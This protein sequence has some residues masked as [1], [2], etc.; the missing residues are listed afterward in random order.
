MRAVSET[1]YELRPARGAFTLVELLVVIGIIALLIAIL[2]PALSRARAA[3]NEV[4][5]LSQLRQIGTAMVMHSQEHRGYMQIA[6][7]IVSPGGGTSDGMEDSSRVRYSYYKDGNVF[8]PLNLAGALAPY[9][10]QDVRTDT[11]D[12]MLADINVGMARKL[13]RCP[14]D[15][16]PLLGFTAKATGWTG[17]TMYNSYGF[18][19]AVLGWRDASSGGTDFDELRGN[20]SSMTNSAATFLMCDA[21]PRNHFVGG[22]LTIFAHNKGATLEDAY[23]NYN[24]R[25]GD[26]SMFDDHRHRGRINVMFV[27]GHGE[28]RFLP[29]RDAGYTADG[30]LSDIYVIAP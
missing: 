24:N 20:V 4:V 22:W 28:A 10:G 29:N 19:E 5:C 7:Q 13:F 25:A 3:S 18:N 23:F 16:T 11:K 1:S 26:A 30:P 2:L 27:D 17:P 6:G 12:N 8:R 14:S 15:E 21:I 9:I